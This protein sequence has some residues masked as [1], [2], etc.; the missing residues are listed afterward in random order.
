M[1]RGQVAP[2]REGDSGGRPLRNERAPGVSPRRPSPA[3]GAV[4]EFILRWLPALLWTGVVLGFSSEAFAAA[5]TSRWLLPLLRGMFPSA[6]PEVLEALHLGI[7]KLAHVVEYA[8]LALLFVRSWSGRVGIE[9]ARDVGRALLLV[10]LVA[11]V[12]EYRQ[13]LSSARTGSIRDWGID[14]GGAL[15]A[16]VVLWAWERIGG[17]R[18]GGARRGGRRVRG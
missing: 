9:S 5:Q 15:L 4:R 7:R 17:S 16:I 1:S 6:D 13:S 11:A 3:L 10:A 2:H 14:L 8:I 18:S 12:D